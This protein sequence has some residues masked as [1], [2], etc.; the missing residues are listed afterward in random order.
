MKNLTLT[1]L[2]LLACSLLSAVYQIGDVVDDLSWTDDSGEEKS[3]YELT[4]QGKVVVMD[5]GGYG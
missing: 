4:G 3:L 2:V 5:W 1:F